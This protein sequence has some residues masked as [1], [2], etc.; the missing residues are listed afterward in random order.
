ME[1]TKNP[2][3]LQAEIDYKE[4]GLRIKNLR[5]RIGLSQE[6][7]SE[8]LNYT[9]HYIYQLESNTRKPSLQSLIRISNYF[10]VSL[11]FI[12]KGYTI[13]KDDELYTLLDSFTDEQRTAIL[14]VI[15]SFLK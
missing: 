10:N 15:K 8:E 14:N 13:S 7:L 6:K 12:I 3:V 1:N 2:N 9:P 5:N 11:D 4:V